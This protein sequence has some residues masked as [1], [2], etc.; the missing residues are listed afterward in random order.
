MKDKAYAIKAYAIYNVDG[1]EK[2]SNTISLN[3][4]IALVSLGD[5]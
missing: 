2:K 1:K 3:Y 5:K 4:R